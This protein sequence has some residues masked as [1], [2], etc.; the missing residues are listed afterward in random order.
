MWVDSIKMEWEDK[1][2][3]VLIV[4]ALVA[5]SAARVMNA[6]SAAKGRKAYAKQVSH[7]VGK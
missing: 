4:V 6:W 3:N 5:N 1:P 7:R 2:L